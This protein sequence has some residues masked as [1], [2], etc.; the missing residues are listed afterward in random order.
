[1]HGLPSAFFVEKGFPEKLSSACKLL[2][3]EKAVWKNATSYKIS[4][5]VENLMIDG[6]ESK[7]YQIFEM[8]K[9]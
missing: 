5:C 8:I 6:V 4:I 2:R 1:L 7:N 9:I 3:S